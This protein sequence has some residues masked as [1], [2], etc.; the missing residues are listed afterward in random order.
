MYKR[1][2][3]F[4]C[5]PENVDKT[6][7]RTM[8]EVAKLKNSGAEAK[9]FEKFVAETRRKTQVDM[10]TNPFWL[11]YIDTSIS[12][13][14]THLDV[15]KRQ[16]LRSHLTFQSGFFRYALRMAITAVGAYYLA[17]VLG[18]EYP[19]WA[20]LTVLVILKPGFSL[21]KARLAHRVY[22]TIV[23]VVV[24]LSLIHI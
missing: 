21:S 24:G 13:S 8:E 2:I 4:G 9:D 18:F 1:Q 3:Q 11:G 16:Y 12:V 22:G 14:Y 20:L 5:A 17:L 6:V 7:K 15:Y 23:G 10:K 19:S